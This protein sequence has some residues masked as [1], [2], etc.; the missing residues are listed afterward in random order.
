MVPKVARIVGVVLGVLTFGFETDVL[1][2]HV[3]RRK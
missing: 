3:M 1:V 2:R